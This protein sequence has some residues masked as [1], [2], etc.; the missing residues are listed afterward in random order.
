[1]ETVLDLIIVLFWAIFFLATLFGV[2]HEYRKHGLGRERSPED[3]LED[4]D[5]V[6]LMGP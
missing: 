4:D 2:I 3:L 5:P 1:M 6:Y